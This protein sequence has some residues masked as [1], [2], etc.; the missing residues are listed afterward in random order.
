MLSKNQIK[1]ITSLQEKKFRL[2]YGL[3]FA[4]G[5]KVIQELLASSFELEHIYG[6][7]FIESSYPKDKFTLITSSEL[8]KISALASPNKVLA[9]FKLAKHPKISFESQNILYCFEDI[10]DPGNLGTILRTA[11]WFGIEY[12]ICSDTS[13]D[14]YNPKVVQ[15]TMGSLA[16]VQVIYTDLL[17]VIK[18]AQE[19]N[20]AIYRADLKGESVYT[21]SFKNKQMIVFGNEARGLSDELRQNLKQ[22]ITIP[23]IGKTESLNVAISAA[24]FMG[25]GAK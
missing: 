16:R 3:F 23:R 4:E 18:E 13:V 10:R 11:D 6:T 19:K 24:I 21:H 17:N 20:Y 7:E 12:I 8:K 9:L 14:V 5:D 25:L 2:K 22:A 15:A 1:V